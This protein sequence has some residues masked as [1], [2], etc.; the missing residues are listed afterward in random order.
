[1][2][3]KRCPNLHYYDG[4]KYDTCPH[5]GGSAAP[6]PSKPVLEPVPEEQPAPAKIPVPEPKPEPVPEPKPESVPEQKPEPVP[7]PKPEPVPEPKPEPVPEP[8]P[9]PVPEPKPEPVPEPKPEP[10]PKPKPESQ[11]APEKWKCTCGQ[12]NIGR[13][14]YQCGKPKPEPKPEPATRPMDAKWICRC[15]AENIGKF[16]YQCGTPK[17]AP[18]PAVSEPPKNWFCKCGAQNTGKFCYQCGSPKPDP[19][20][21][22]HYDDSFSAK[23]EDKRSLT[24]QIDEIKYSGHPEDAS[25]GS[26]EGVTRIIF[27]ELGDELV[28]GWLTVVNTSEKGKVYTLKEA[29]STLGRSDADHRVD[30]D[31]HSDRTVSRGAQAVIVYDPL[32]KKFFI[33]STGGKSLIYVNREMLLAPAALKA[34]DII[35][36]GETEMVFVP[37]C[38]EKFSW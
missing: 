6:A 28:I 11:S 13:F 36:L 19:A 15:G 29:K 22:G 7:E 24:Q 30:V 5:C 14:C 4:D 32:N 12:E 8:K 16:C 26:D 38:T 33:Q 3:L 1:M 31:L 25:V 17:P 35:R 23:A 2:K 18:A 10:V 37:L 34:Y 20:M 27:D 9:E 21:V